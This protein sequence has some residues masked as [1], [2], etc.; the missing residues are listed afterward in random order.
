MVLLSLKPNLAKVISRA[1]EI[2][3][4]YK[5]VYC[6]Q[7]APAV[8]FLIHSYPEYTSVDSLPAATVDEKVEIASTLYDKGLLIT[9]EP[10][11]SVHED[12]DSSED[13]S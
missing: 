13:D 10:L 3:L 2:S 7:L 4:F 11:D 8:E 1:H 5:I 9:G 6:L 12:H